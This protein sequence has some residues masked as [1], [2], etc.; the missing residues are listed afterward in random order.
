MARHGERQPG[1]PRRRAVNPY[2][3]QSCNIEYGGEPG[4]P[5]LLLVLGAIIGQDRVREVT[6]QQLGRPALPLYE[7]LRQGPGE[8]RTRMAAE[9]FDRARG[10]ASARI[11]QGDVD[12]A[13]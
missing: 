6:F 8:V 4:E 10:R 5:G 13:L 7:G 9:Q 1:A 3:E 2:Q 12:L 11:E